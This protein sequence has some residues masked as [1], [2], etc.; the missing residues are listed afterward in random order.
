M[1]LNLLVYGYLTNAYSSWK[2]KEQIR[3]NIYFILQ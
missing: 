3:K 2:L 1:L